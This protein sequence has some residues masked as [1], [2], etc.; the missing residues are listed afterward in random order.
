VNPYQHQKVL[1]YHYAQQQLI[2]GKSHLTPRTEKYKYLNK[3]I[4]NIQLKLDW[5]ILL[6]QQFDQNRLNFH[7]NLQDLN[8]FVKMKNSK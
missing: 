5:K 4:Q 6:V 7:L 8:W 3:N 1:L 2:L